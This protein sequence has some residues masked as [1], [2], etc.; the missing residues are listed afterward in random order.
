ML[1]GRASAADANCTVQSGGNITL[2]DVSVAAGVAVG[3]PIGSPASTTVNFR[4]TSVPASP[5][6]DNLFLQAGNLAA[7][8]PLDTK[9][10]GIIYATNVPG[11]AVKITG[12]PT[13]A[14]SDSCH[15]CGPGAGPGFEMG[16]VTGSGSTRNYSNTFTAQLI[17][18][19]PITPGSINSISLMQF[20]AYEYGY[21]PSDPYMSTAL[22][23]TSGTDVTVKSC[24]VNSD[25]TNMTVTLP[26]IL[27]TQLGSAV[28]ST[29]GRTRF[30]INL[31][32][33]TGAT[34]SVQMNSGNLA[35]A[36]LGLL[37]NT[38]GTGR[39][40]NVGVQ[41]LKE[42]TNPMPFNS[43]QPL[44]AT[45]NGQWRVPFYVQYYRTSTNTIGIG[46]VS[47][48]AT[49]TLTYQ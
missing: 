49:F 40:T 11:V 34:A 2:A 46:T 7:L 26:T 16:P 4:C 15:R 42:D 28:G 9:A 18:T 8:D 37:S 22:V 48:S 29:A 5:K 12:S 35:T 36:S 14:S 43:T 33:E 41:V 3:A 19:G 30:T 32:C 38:T 6:G 20:T 23:L 21:T 39:A 44:G 1:P 31:T 24:S 17:K 47:T 10:N 45:P 25:S 13:Q 27:R